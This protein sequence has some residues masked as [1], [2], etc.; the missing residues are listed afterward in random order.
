MKIVR[1]VA[2]LCDK[3]VA[4]G[5]FEVFGGHFFHEGAEVGLWRPAEFLAGLGCV[6]E[7]GFHFGRAEVTRV[8]GYDGFAALVVGLLLAATVDALLPRD[9]LIR[10]LG[11][12]R[13]RSSFLGGALALP[14]MM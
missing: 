9:W 6:P 3:G 7:Q 11:S 2:V 5:G 8:D 4:L 14:G 12:A 13:V 1:G 10:V